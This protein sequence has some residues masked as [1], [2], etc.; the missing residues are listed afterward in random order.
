IMNI[1]L[2]FYWSVELTLVSFI[3]LPVSAFVI[4]RIGKS[5][6]RTAKQ[7]QEQLSL[8]FSTIDESLWGIRIIKAFN[9]SKYVEKHF[10]K[11]N[12]R[13]QQ[14]ITK[15]FRKKDLSSPLNEFL[16]TIVMV[17]LVWFGGKMILDAKENSGLNGET[18]LTFIIIFSQ[19]LRPIQQVAA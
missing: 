18:F 12:L 7:G 4:S 5:L 8:L 16:G 11:V 9:A 2:L 14:L 15:T 17:C 19:L 13:H 10:K 6:K 1:A 3:L